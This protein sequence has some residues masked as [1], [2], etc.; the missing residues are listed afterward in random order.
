MSKP[1]TAAGYSPGQLQTVRATCLSLASI[2][3]DL[4]D[5]LVVV[6]GLVP[7]LLID[8]A[9]SRKEPHVGSLDVDVG[10]EVAI[11]DT[12]RYHTLAE[13]L[14]GR[15][16]EPDKNE[17]GNPTRQRW[18][19]KRFKDV[20]VDFLMAP[21]GAAAPGTLQD[22]E[23]DLAAVVTP[24]LSLAFRDRQ[25]IRLADRTLDGEAITRDIPVCG[26]GAFVVLK[27]LAFR[28]RG[29]N[30]DAYD[31]WYLLGHFGDS[32]EDVAAHLR[33]LLDDANAREAVRVLGED[34]ATLDSHGPRRAAEF[35]SRPGDDE[36]C[37]DVAGLVS[38]LLR[39]L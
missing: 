3:G 2:L 36:F 17:Q 4:L 31:L 10:L 27:A 15:D 37:S 32:V 28:N 23:A 18:T 7:S 8:S 25:R 38:R 14:R 1:K 29:E 34:F 5:D 35:L 20:R 13:R 39:S 24:G 12:G 26:A 16:F 6:G 30:K 19:H 22:L 21:V 11:L 9:A 33:Q